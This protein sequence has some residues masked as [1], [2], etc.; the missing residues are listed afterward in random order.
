MDRSLVILVLVAGCGPP[1]TPA[2]DGTIIGSTSVAIDTRSTATRVGEAPVGDFIADTLLAAT[3]ARGGDATVA[4]VNSGAIRGG[5]T[6]RDAVPVDIDAKLGRVYGPGALTDHD[7]EGWIPF[8]DDHI[9]ITVTAAQ[10]K[11]ALERGA[12]QLPPDLLLDGGGPLLQIAGARYTID[13]SGM[14]QIIV[15]GLDVVA[16]E[17]TRIS[18]LKIGGRV[19]WDR[20]AGIDELAT[21]DVRLVVNTFVSDGFDG[22]IALTEGRDAEELPYDAFNIADELVARVMATSPIAPTRDGRI[23]IVGDCGQPLTLP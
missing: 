23:T 7:V 16:Q 6:T 9:I 20:D 22:H 8:R 19:V 13:C 21:T 10:L 2:G 4:L 17:G 15:P 14:V 3:R 5:R 12:A 18:R 11:S 1:S